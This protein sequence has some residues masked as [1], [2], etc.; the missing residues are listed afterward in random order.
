MAHRGWVTHFWVVW[1]L[2]AGGIAGAADAPKEAATQCHGEYFRAYLNSDWAALDKLQRGVLSHTSHM[3]AAQRSDVVYIRKTAGTYRPSWWRAC[4]STKKTPIP[5]AV[6]G[7]KTPVIYEPGNTPGA[8]GSID[9]ATRRLV[10]TLNWNPSLVDNSEPAGGGLAVKHGIT[11]GDLGETIVWRQL[12]LAYLLL[13]AMRQEQAIALT[14]KHQHL[15]QHLWTYYG[16]M[17]A[18][19]HSSPRGRRAALLDMIRGMQ[20]KSNHEGFGRACRAAAALLLATVLA[21]PSKWPSIE[22]PSEVPDGDVERKTA[23]HVLLNLDPDW[24]LAEDRALRAVLEKHFR[25]NAQTVIRTR[26]KIILP[27]KTVFMLQEPDDR[28]PLDKR[29]SWIEKQLKKARK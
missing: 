18:L 2:A 20:G 1:V 29:N 24:T 6:W 14:Q 4:S 8:A 23:E 22:L 16:V 11:Q 7:S 13:N 26:G 12:G 21:E 5:A 3:T 27:N 19:Y 28:A 17:T 25:A 15:Y 9:A 10:F